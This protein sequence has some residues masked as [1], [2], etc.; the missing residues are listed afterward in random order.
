[1]G[2]VEEKRGKFSEGFMQSFGKD[3]DDPTD[4]DSI[5]CNCVFIAVLLTVAIIL[6][7]L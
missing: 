3:P 4:M 7:I 1:M 5:G 6:S 2:E